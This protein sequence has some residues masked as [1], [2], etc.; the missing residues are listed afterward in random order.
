MPKWQPTSIWTLPQD[1]PQTS[2]FPLKTGKELGCGR[3]GVKH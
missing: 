1:L 3:L 2:S